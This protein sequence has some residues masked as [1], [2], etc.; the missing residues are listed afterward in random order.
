MEETAKW[1][2][3]DF[4]LK[5]FGE[6]W[7]DSLRPFSPVSSGIFP[8]VVVFMGSS[9]G[10]CLPADIKFRSRIKNQMMS[11][12]LCRLELNGHNI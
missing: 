6:Y 8:I 10:L 4:G 7:Q 3:V 5:Q 12:I 11:F 2:N 9:S 1:G